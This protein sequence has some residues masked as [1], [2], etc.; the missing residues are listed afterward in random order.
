MTGT[1]GA[2]DEEATEKSSRP[3]RE[4]HW[5]TLDPVAPSRASPASSGE[6]RPAQAATG[7]PPFARSGACVTRVP[8]SG[9]VGRAYTEGHLCP[10]PLQAA[11]LRPSPAPRRACSSPAAPE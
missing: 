8:G 7:A 3:P 6:L 2:V 11:L 1:R 4:H 10:A 9:G 5:P